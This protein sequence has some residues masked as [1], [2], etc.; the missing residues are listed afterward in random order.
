MA[1]Y[2]VLIE[3]VQTFNVLVNLMMVLFGHLVM[4][5]SSDLKLIFIL[6]LDSPNNGTKLKRMG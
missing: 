6:H 5:T 4:A 3:P 1:L 2:I